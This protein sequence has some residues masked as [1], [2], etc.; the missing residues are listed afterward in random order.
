MV[1][2]RERRRVQEYW[3][4]LS[5]TIRVVDKHRAEGLIPAPWS[6]RPVARCAPT[7]LRA[8]RKEGA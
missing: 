5:A 8:M 6:P 2:W 1:A 4:A 3:A 7:G